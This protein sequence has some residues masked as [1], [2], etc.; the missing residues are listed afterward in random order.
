MCLGLIAGASLWKDRPD[1]VALYDL[2]ESTL[3]RYRM[4]A[5]RFDGPWLNL[6]TDDQSDFFRRRIP[7]CKALI[8]RLLLNLGYHLQTYYSYL[9][10]PRG[11][12]SHTQGGRKSIIFEQARHERTGCVIQTSN[13][14][15]A[16]TFGS[17]NQKNRTKTAKEANHETAGLHLCFPSTSTPSCC[18]PVGVSTYVSLHDRI[19]IYGSPIDAYTVL[20]CLWIGL[21]ASSNCPFASFPF[22]QVYIYIHIHVGRPGPARYMPTKAR[23][24]KAHI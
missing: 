7:F 14:S 23:L 22:L 2:D 17:R 10:G 19:S 3:Y 21:H 20:Y 24:T 12:A 6:E 11:R 13:N 1:A 18:T 9:G 8:T 16:Q 4:H 15:K 5:E